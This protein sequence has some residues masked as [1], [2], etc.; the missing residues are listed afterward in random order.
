[1]LSDVEKA[2]LKPRKTW[3]ENIE[4]TSSRRIRVSQ[5]G[6]D[7]RWEYT[8]SSLDAPDFFVPQPRRHGCIAKSLIVETNRLA[9]STVRE[10]S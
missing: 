4:I 7:D 1:M 9:T 3:A 10:D 6:W 2:N 8:T 5:F